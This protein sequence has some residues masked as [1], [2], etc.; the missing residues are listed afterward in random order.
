MATPGKTPKQLRAEADG[1]R[2]KATE[3]GGPAAVGYRQLADE[4]L[5]AA[6]ELEKVEQAKPR[7]VKMT[8]PPAVQP[9][10]LTKAQA[11]S[12]AIQRAV[13][14]ALRPYTSDI[15]HVEN[16]GEEHASRIAALEA[17]VARLEG[18]PGKA[19]PASSVP[20][21]AEDGDVQKAELLAKADDA[22]HDPTLA[23]GYRDRAAEL[24]RKGM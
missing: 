7:P 21:E 10:F 5:A 8:R 18:R 2:T 15:E 22:R 9:G 4:A 23:Q 11:P 3:V 19:I 12:D 17:R 20:S 13:D 1:Y 24:D 6:V 14:N 16:Q